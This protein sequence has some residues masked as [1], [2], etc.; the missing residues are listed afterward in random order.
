[1]NKLLFIAALLLCFTADAQKKNTTT[2]KKAKSKTEKPAAK[3]NIVTLNSKTL[4]KD[5]LY[6]GRIKNAVRWTDKSGDNIVVTTET[7]EYDAK[8]SISGEG[9]NADLAVQHYLVLNGKSV[10][11]WKISD[12]IRDCP[13][14]IQLH[15]IK[16]TFHITDLDKDGTAE[17]WTMYKSACRGDL[18]PSDTKIVMYE[19]RQKYA[20]RGTN[21]VQVSE[22]EVFGGEYKPDDAFAKGPKLFR[23][24]ARE[25]WLK[26]E[27]EVWYNE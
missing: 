20:V 10:P 19:G 7:P 18:G 3:L 23:D 17:V 9:R 22:H 2:K 8:K 12:R 6:E 5:I 15:F 26:N 24:H 25:L 21:K 1:M 14:D 16:N 13:L 27:L 4:P 11:D